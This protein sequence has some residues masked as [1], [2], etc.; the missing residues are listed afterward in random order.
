MLYSYDL[1]P[2]ILDP[3]RI[4]NTTQSIIDQI[5][6][7][8]F[9]I[10]K[11]TVQDNTI[12]DHRTVLFSMNCGEDKN[13][14]EK[15]H[16]NSRM[17]GSANLNRL[18]YALS[19]ETWTDVYLAN[20]SDAKFNNF[21]D[22]LIYYFNKECPHRSK[23]CCKKTG[24]E[25]VNNPIKESSEN[26]K[27]LF[28]LQKNNPNLKSN[29]IIAKKQHNNLVRQTKSQFYLNKIHNSSNP[30]KST[31]NIISE[32]TGK[33]RLQ[34]N[35][36][37]EINDNLIVNPQQISEEFNNFFINAP[38][39]TINK[40]TGPT[41]TTNLTTDVNKTEISN[42][43]FLS[44]ITEQEILSIIK[45]KLKNKHS[46]GPDEISSNLIKKIAEY[47]VKPLTHIINESFTD[48][49]FPSRLKTA[50][51]SPIF[52]KGVTSNMANYRPISVP[53]IISKIYE[54]AMLSQLLKFLEVNNILSSKQHGFRSG[55]S[56]I[57]AV[58][59]FYEKILEA[60]DA[61]ESP[62]GIFCDLSRA[63]DC[64]QH[65]LLLKKLYE[66]GIRGTPYDWFASYL[67]GRNQMVKIQ[68]LE[69]NQKTFHTSNILDNKV[70]VPQGSVLGPVLFI[71][72]INELPN[73]L[74]EAF[75]SLY[76]DDAT[77][78][79]SDR[80]HVSLL[81]KINTTVTDLCSWFRNH[82]LY[83]NVSK[84]NH[85]TFHTR[86][87]T[88]TPS[89]DIK[90]NNVDIEESNC[91]TFLGII[92]DNTLT[93]STHCNKLI[94]T[95]H[96]KC[97]Q[98][99]ALK[100]VLDMSGLLTFYFGQ[101]QSRLTYG[102]TVWGGSSSVNDVFIAQKRIIRCIAGVTSTHSC[103]NLFKQYK[104]LPLPSL[105]VLELLL[106]VYKNQDKFDK[107]EMIHLHNTRCKSNFHIPTKRL[108]ISTKAHNILGLK[109]YNH[110]PQR[111]K[112]LKNIFI[113]KKYVKEYLL[114]MCAYSIHEY[115]D[116][117]NIF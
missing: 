94:S 39:E 58:H 64:V 25:W 117:A 91:T 61:G 114:N 19:N 2:R 79:L 53:P 116:Y 49:I 100:S 24:K 14:S 57:T 89:I 77:L 16:I 48:G 67:S 95:L 90:I 51:V 88:N 28:Y 63:F 29:Y 110:L 54:Y 113:F 104:I 41:S 1:S 86:Q 62:T 81:N 21:H 65:D 43:M 32:L 35:I 102:I 46:T 33:P 66:Y 101:I 60:V 47:I 69:Q 36:K 26:L 85:M 84:T 38:Y 40:I 108:N 30:N 93:F 76:A 4:S 50:L 44:Y 107:N 83:F 22:T 6:T 70:G 97:F 74:T 8:Q 73:M 37:L 103:R 98:I 55:Y 31:W 80:A 20:G 5:Y 7:N 87:N 112:S 106:Y 15:I 92:F 111:Y 71:I 9:S 42:S 96:S 34:E 105:Y 17:C 72:Y 78:L 82:L 27:Q 68:Y 12:S 11:S 75:V 56:T 13:N 115:F 99:R 52:K 59:S 3:T 45:D 109:L 23:K 18:I 10:G